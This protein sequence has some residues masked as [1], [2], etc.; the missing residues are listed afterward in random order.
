MWTCDKCGK[1]VPLDNDA[2]AL[3][4]IRHFDHVPGP[5]ER[6]EYGARHLFATDDCEGSPSRAQYLGA[7]RDTRGHP[8]LEEYE[9]EWREAYRDLL[10]I[11]GG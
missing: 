1:E 5:M 11:A 3:D 7:E 2:V 8:Y 10:S 9:L 6:F 4:H